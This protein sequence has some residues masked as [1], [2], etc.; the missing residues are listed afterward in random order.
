MSKSDYEQTV[1]ADPLLLEAF[2]TC[3]PQP[4]VCCNGLAMCSDLRLSR[5]SINSCPPV[6]SIYIIKVS[7]AVD[8]LAFK[9]H[10]HCVQISVY[11]KRR[12]RRQ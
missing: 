2:G 1:T 11:I 9:D 7:N 5:W 10:I 3:L 6:P 12:A 4:R 8:L